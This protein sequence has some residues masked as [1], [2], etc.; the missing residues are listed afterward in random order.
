MSRIRLAVL[1]VTCLGMLALPGSAS[2]FGVLSSFGSYGEDAGQMS[3]PG[4]LDVAEDGTTYVADFGN[5]RIDAFSPTGGFER[6]FGNGVNPDGTD[7][8]VVS[9]QSGLSGA[10]TEEEAG[11]MN[12]P[13]DVALGTEGN[14]FVADRRNNRIDVFAASG[15]FLRA[16]GSEVEGGT[17]GGDLCTAF[18]GCRAGVPGPGAGEIAEPFG[19]AFG[20]GDVYVADAENNRID[21]Y[22]PAGT[23]LY[24][25]G[26]HVDTAIGNPDRCISA[27]GAGE[28]TGAAGAIA[29][30]YSL[31][32]GPGGGNL[33][34]TDYL[35]DRV[36][37]FSPEGLFLFA[38]GKAVG[39]SGADVCTPQTGCEEGVKGSGAGE[40]DR[41]TAIAV[42]STG[43]V[44]V[45]DEANNRVEEFT[46]AGAFVRAFGQ[47]VRDGGAE[48][49][50][51][52]VGEQCVAGADGTPSGAISHPYGLA[53]AGGKIYVS[54]EQEEDQLARVEV[55][56]DPAVPG[57]PNPP[58]G[59]TPGQSTPPAGVPRPGPP[60]PNP[61]PSNKFKVGK[62]KLNLRKGTA[63]LGVVLP[64]PGSVSL[65]GKGVK[66]AATRTRKATTVK[67]PVRLV[68]KTRKALL[69]AGAAK[70]VVA[71]TYTPLG[72]TPATASRTLRL[73]QGPRR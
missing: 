37:V 6:A 50:V 64:G 33:Y 42:D 5:D 45:A 32:F 53:A 71:V 23:F 3:F 73:K 58:A 11:A 41:P 61:T 62:L 70:V 68:G 47:G 39:T 60:P 52:L 17:G 46:G 29:E 34:V 44:L 7:V 35:N 48:F 63:T 57:G 18:T 1:V 38:F 14:L 28:G 55:F 31:A 2:A 56:G 30:P 65:G 40:L 72:G 15:T 8:C 36:D 13:E 22:S 66:S 26:R 21:V 12:G 10:E 51:C 25:F 43:H 69:K 59:E 27:C 24:A 16:F 20:A 54:E 9:C 49:Q 67:L 4:S 19:V